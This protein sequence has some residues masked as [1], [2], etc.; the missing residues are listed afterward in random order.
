MIHRYLLLLMFSLPL[1]YGCSLTTQLMYTPEIN[2]AEAL[3]RQGKNKE[4]AVIYKELAAL[5]TNQRNQFH[6]LAADA[7]ISSG[8]AKQGKKYIDTINSAQLTPVQFNYLK[9]LQA[10]VLMNRGDARKALSLFQSMNVTSLEDRSKFAYYDSLALAYSLLDNPLKSIEALIFLDPF[11]TSSKTRLQHYDKILETLIAAPADALKPQSSATKTVNGWLSLAKLLG[12]NQTNLTSSLA[13][14]RIHNPNHPVDSNLLLSYQKK[15]KQRFT[16]PA[17]IAVFLPNSGPYRSAAKVIKK[18]FMAAYDIKKQQ[19]ANQQKII[20]YDTEST[21]IVS[22]YHQAIKKGAQLII[23]PLN[24]KHLRSLVNNTTLNVPVLALNH[25][26]GLNDPRLYQFGLSPI[27]DAEQVANRAYLDGY[28]NALLLLPQSKRGQ[29]IGNYFSNHW[30]QLGAI[31][32]NR[33]NYN[34]GV[35]NFNATVNN[36]ADKTLS[37]GSVNVI[38]MNASAQQASFLNP[39]LR[40]HQETANIPIYATSD[41]Y[42]NSSHN[43]NLNGITFCD[44]PWIFENAYKGALNKTALYSLWGGLSSS[45]LRLLPLGID[46]YNLIQHLDTLKTTPYSGA[47]GKL[48]LSSDNRINRELFCA[49]FVNGKPHLLGFATQEKQSTIPIITTST[50]EIKPQNTI[51]GIE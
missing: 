31:V 39:L 20:F 17:T 38:F 50:V 6:L 13:K 30:Q 10:Q 22:L 46:A 32:A 9:L 47:T 14:W 24:K 8:D 11:I 36:V 41:V 7:L 34:T 2:Q 1:L 45:Y 18:G 37:N 15:Y 25:V 3:L 5:N 16:S 48:T 49:Q 19:T 33:H 23:G 40:Y 43:E 42:D 51:T 44:V 29:R 12:S 4:A 21:N 27:D 26:E 35:K 28:N